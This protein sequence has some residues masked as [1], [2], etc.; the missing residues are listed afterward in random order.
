LY[1]TLVK[2]NALLTM[3]VMV[4]RGGSENGEDEFT[5]EK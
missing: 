5:G 2:G 3:H 1:F 4:W